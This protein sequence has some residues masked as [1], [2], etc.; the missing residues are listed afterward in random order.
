MDPRPLW[1]DPALVSL[2]HR[3]GA[4]PETV[5]PGGPGGLRAA[6]TDW[7]L[8]YRRATL[9]MLGLAETDALRDA[10]CPALPAA[11]APV[12]GVHTSAGCPRESYRSVIIAQVVE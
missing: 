6:A 5:D 1:R 2:K 8:E 3:R 12:N 9:A 10:R 11:P 7:E 4:A